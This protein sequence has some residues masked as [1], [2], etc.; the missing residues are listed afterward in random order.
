[1]NKNKLLYNAAM[2]LTECAK[3]VKPVDKDFVNL[4]LDKAKEFANKI[5]IDEKLEHEVDE[6]EKRIRKE[7]KE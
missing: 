3:F 6:F 5:V 1:M 7:L 2:A 4:M